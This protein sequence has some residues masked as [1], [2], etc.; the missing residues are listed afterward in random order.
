MIRN[1]GNWYFAHIP[2]HPEL[3]SISGTFSSRFNSVAYYFAT[4]LI[5]RMRLAY[6]SRSRWNMG[7]AEM[8]Y[9]S[10]KIGISTNS[11]EI[12]LGSL[13]FF[14][15]PFSFSE[16]NYRDMCA[17]T[18]ERCA[19]KEPLFG[20][21]QEYTFLRQ[22]SHPLGWAKMGFPG[23]QGELPEW[24]TDR[25]QFKVGY[26]YN[27]ASVFHEMHICGHWYKAREQRNCLSWSGIRTSNLSIVLLSPSTLNIP[28]NQGR[29]TR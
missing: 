28:R 26:H 22:D 16:T 11:K 3:R 20:F 25:K 5:S 4:E 14:P 12:K 23:P 6:W 19:D 1:T 10:Y 18:S 9:C 15:N 24:V 29:K 13:I 2:V 7:Y 8:V 21:E 27:Y 17:K